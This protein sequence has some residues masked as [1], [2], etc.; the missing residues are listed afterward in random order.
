MR[1]G[2]VGSRFKSVLRF[3]VY[4]MSAKLPHGI[5]LRIAGKFNNMLDVKKKK[6][7]RRGVESGE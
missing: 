2:A 7:K 5:I 1:F 4:K 3:P 6:K